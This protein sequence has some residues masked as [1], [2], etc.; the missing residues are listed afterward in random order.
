MALI[1]PNCYGTHLGW[2]LDVVL[3]GGGPSLMGDGGIRL[4]EVSPALV[5]GC[6]ECSETIRTVTGEE[7]ELLLSTIPVVSVLEVHG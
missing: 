6:V 1:C 2:S 3:L 5:L 7:A 4:H